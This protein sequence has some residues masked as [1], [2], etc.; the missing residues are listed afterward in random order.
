MHRVQNVWVWPLFTHFHFIGRILFES[1]GRKIKLLYTEIPDLQDISY[2]TYLCERP[3]LKDQ[4][5]QFE[6]NVTDKRIF[7]T[8]LSTFMKKFLKVNVLFWDQKGETS[9]LIG[10]GS[11]ISF[12]N[13]ATFRL[14]YVLMKIAP[15]KK[16]QKVTLQKNTVRIHVI[17]SFL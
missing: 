2:N 4:V 10:P 8:A 17:L 11:L 16:G 3:S 14:S 6:V 13:G 12:Q 7:P 9:F 5:I 1:Q 15:S